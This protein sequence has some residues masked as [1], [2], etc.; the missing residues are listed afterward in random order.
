MNNEVRLKLL[1][2]YMQSD[3]LK[4]FIRDECIKYK[5]IIYQLPYMS[6]EDSMMM[7][8]LDVGYLVKA[9]WEIR[10]NLN[11]D[12]LITGALL[13]EYKRIDTTIPERL[14]AL[15]E[16]NNISKLVQ[17]LIINVIISPLEENEDI[18]TIKTAEALVIRHSIKLAD[19]IPVCE[20]EGS[21]KD[22]QKY[23]PLYTKV[24]ILT[25]PIKINI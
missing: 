25:K 22:G 7:H 8:V 21:V 13:H 17:S 2:N 19:I 16:S 18:L 12:Y 1:L 10:N 23:Y 6:E 4:R 15:L 20:L 14:I 24:P 5:S 9:I 11:Y 3:L